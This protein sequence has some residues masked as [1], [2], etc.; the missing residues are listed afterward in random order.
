MN[1]FDHYFK[2]A[3]CTIVSVTMLLAPTWAWGT[4]TNMKAIGREAQSFGTD[5]AKSALDN[6]PQLQGNSLSIPM[7]EGNSLSFDTNELSNQSDVINRQWTQQ[8]IDELRGLFDGSD[9]EGVEKGAKAKE[10]L[11][12]NTE[13]LEGQIHQIMIDGSNQVPPDWTKDKIILE[14]QKILEQFDTNDITDC[15]TDTILTEKSQTIHRPVLEQCEQVI[16]R[17]G[18]CTITH[19]YRAGVIRHYDGSFNFKNCGEG[20]TEMWLSRP[21]TGGGGGGKYCKLHAFELQFQV[22][23]PDAIVKAT[24]DDIYWDDQMQLY[25]GPIGKEEKILQLPY[26]T[27][28]VPEYDEHPDV[29]PAFTYP[30]PFSGA[31]PTACEQ[32]WAWYWRNTELDITPWLK[33]AKKNDVYRFLMRVAIAGN[34]GGAYA[35]LRVYY[36]PAKAIVDD[37]WVPPEC[38]QNVY[39]IN[40]KFAKGKYECVEMPPL[41]SRGCAEIDGVF[42]CPHHLNPSPLPGIS[43]LCTKVNVNANYDFYKGKMDCWTDIHGNLQC[44]ENNGGALDKCAKLEERGC[45]FISSQCSDGA[46][47]AS[48]NCYVVDATYDCGED[49]VIKDTEQKEQTVCKG[50]ISCMGED[51]IGI[52]ETQSQSFAKA[53]A[54]MNSLQYMAKDMQCTGLD[55]NDVPTGEENVNC[56]VFAGNASKCKIAVGGI[57][58]C[59]ENQ[60]P[61]GM[62]PYLGMLIAKGKGEYIQG[63]YTTNETSWA[64][65]AG[66]AAGHGAWSSTIGAVGQASWAV[67]G[68]LNKFSSFVEN[69]N[70]WHDIFAPSMDVLVAHSKTALE[71]YI[72]DQLMEL[73]K[74]AA[75]LIGEAVGG[76]GG[77]G[78]GAAGAEGAAGTVGGMASAALGVIAAVYAAYC[79]A[80]MIIQAVYKCTE[81]EMQLTAMRDVGNCHYIGSYC[82]D[83]KLGVCIKK[84]RSYCCFTSP[85]SRIIQEQLR[86]QGDVLGPEFNGFGSAKHPVCG[87]LPLEK[88]GDIDWDRI[89]LS[90]WIAI[91][92]QNGK[93]PNSNTVDMDKLTGAA[94]PLNFDKNRVNSLERNEERIK[95]I[96]IDEERLNAQKEYQPD[97]GYRGSYSE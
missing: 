96:D 28:F 42:V 46:L 69:I 52:T 41:D 95:Y 73:F 10:K 49:V 97:T 32:R 77:A 31:N 80:V 8:D 38:V 2:K 7:P 53:T 79:L 71:M 17:S 4:D 64:G 5:S 90:E 86:K 78:A 34:I 29:R 93:L 75:N 54:L 19:D 92:E 11:F 18:K 62:S 26:A 83:K 23:N 63:S 88:I 20:C 39:A 27:N 65:A 57:S 33:K 25:L 66:E 68:Y 47:G 6:P 45:Q 22:M 37:A 76:G 30:G 9:D 61:V 13:T 91:L 67:A 70:S 55:E 58:D 14:T 16:D 12:G 40:D 84:K 59:C 87:G 43:N 82:D 60:A 48:G 1:H 51:C 44:P 56:S 81:E 85:L 35:R 89:D 74:E 50:D 24:L 72:K 15:K 21:F 3:V 36:D 94:S